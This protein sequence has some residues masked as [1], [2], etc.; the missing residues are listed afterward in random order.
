MRVS[1]TGYE[2]LLGRLMRSA[3]G[4]GGPPTSRRPRLIGRGLGPRLRLEIFPTVDAG[5]FRLRLRAPDG[6]HIERTE[7]IALRGARRSIE[8]TVGADNVASDAR[9]RRHD[10]VQLPDQRRL[11]VDAR[12]GGGDAAGGAEARHAASRSKQFKET[13]RERAGRRACPSVRF[14][15]EPADIVNEVMSF[16]SP[17]PIEVAVS[18]PNLA[19]NRALRRQ[20]AGRAG[21]DRL[22]CATCRS[23]SR[24]TTR[25]SRSR[26]TARRPGCSGV[27]GRR[28]GPV[29][30]R[31]PPRQPLRR[32][33]LLA[34][35][36]DR[37]RLP[38]AG[39][40]SAAG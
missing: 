27:H 25:P 8:E 3:G 6:T 4:A 18:G 40:D 35:S 7:Q 30:G 20:G 33:E 37:H 1:R 36:E 29:A 26:S 32:A 14:S 23:P 34:R 13:L 9:L 24:S 5:Q 31:R 10:P 2:R 39:R 11:P 28:G 17:T 12:A 19:D 22:R 15:F 38:G 16:G 21:A